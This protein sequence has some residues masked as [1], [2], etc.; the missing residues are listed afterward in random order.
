MSIIS[1][2]IELIGSKGRAKV[3]ALFDSGASFSCIPPGLAKKLGV[4]T[5]LV[6]PVKLGTA[7]RGKKLQVNEL[8]SLQ[9]RINGYEFLD[10]FM[11]VPGLSEE[12]I[13][14]AK[15]MQA[16]RIKLDLE[17][18]EVIIDPKATKLRI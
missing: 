8:V 2:K 14:G 11:V 7:A 18:E 13:I 12:T 4:V 6:L 3:E 5:P 9:F 17:N 16:W 15:T 10:D 1:R